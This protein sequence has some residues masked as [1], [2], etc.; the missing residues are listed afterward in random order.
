MTWKDLP[1]RERYLR[2]YYK[3]HRQ[4]INKLA[5][6]SKIRRRDFLRQIKM[7]RGCFFC[8]YRKCPEALQFHHMTGEKDFQLSELSQSMERLYA[9]LNKCMVI[10]ANCHFELHH[11]GIR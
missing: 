9:E 7:E 1:R 8:G 4:Q 5:Q 10:C 2:K 3:E 11:G 6:E